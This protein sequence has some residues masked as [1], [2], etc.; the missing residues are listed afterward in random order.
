MSNL[1]I[2]EMPLMVIPA[3]AVKIGLNE[4]LVLQ[5]IHYWVKSSTKVIEG[6]KWIYNTYKEWQ[7]QFPFWSESTI[8]RAI[9]SL[10]NQGLIITGNWNRSKMDKTKWYTIDYERVE[11][12]EARTDEISNPQEEPSIFS[13]SNL[14][15]TSLTEVIPNHPSESKTEQKIPTAEIINY[16]N[17]KTYSSYKPSTHTTKEKIQARFREGFTLADFKKVIGLKTA[18][19]LSHPKMSKYLRPE[20]LF[21]N[22]FESYLNQKSSKKIYHEEDFNLD[23]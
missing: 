20:T 17:E 23:D 12:L 10:E 3:L 4:A 2:S 13:E 16:L 21:G 6:R 22:K 18:E 15:D 11:A 9:H 8:K 14:E 7:L 1:L 5:Q 19:W